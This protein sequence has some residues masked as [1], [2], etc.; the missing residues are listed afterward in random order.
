MEYIVSNEELQASI[1]T[2]KDLILELGVYN[3]SGISHDVRMD[4]LHSNLN[5]LVDLQIE[6]ASIMKD[7][8]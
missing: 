6:R 8:E 1:N 5:K 7:K 2:L 3:D 4:K